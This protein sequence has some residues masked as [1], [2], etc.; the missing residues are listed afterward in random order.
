MGHFLKYHLSYFVC[1][2]GFPWFLLDSF[3]TCGPCL[4]IN[5]SPPL[6][7]KVV[8][9][10]C[11][12]CQFNQSVSL[13]PENFPI[14]YVSHLSLH[15]VFAYSFIGNLKSL[16]HV[17]TLTMWVHVPVVFASHLYLPSH[18]PYQI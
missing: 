2:R 15:D 13:I 5:I 11:K 3:K 8:Y 17:P 14:K 10:F 7:K 12:I 9:L 16:A 18:L 6:P 1:I 4:I